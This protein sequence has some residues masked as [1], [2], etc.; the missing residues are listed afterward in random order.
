MDA[1]RLKGGAE[2]YPLNS[3]GYVGLRVTVGLAVGLAL[4]LAS[5]IL[6]L[7]RQGKLIAIAESW[8]NKK[9]SFIALV[10]CF[11]FDS[12]LLFACCLI[13]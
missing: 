13:L 8:K 4:V 7:T 5:P 9:V 6:A 1:P 10:V 3:P 11:D 12:E 2:S